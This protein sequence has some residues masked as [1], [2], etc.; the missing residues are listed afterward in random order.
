MKAGKYKIPF[1]AGNLASGVY[2]YRISSKD[3]SKVKK[4]VLIK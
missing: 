3:F 1:A 2:F 4:M